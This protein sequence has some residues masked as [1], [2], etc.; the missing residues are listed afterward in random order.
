MCH[1]IQACQLGWFNTFSD[2]FRWKFW[3]QTTFLFLHSIMFG[4]FNF[5]RRLEESDSALGLDYPE[6]PFHSLYSVHN[7]VVLAFLASFY[8]IH[9]LSLRR[10]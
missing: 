3:V 5:S 7:L 6:T 1:E 4:E 2:T 9:S 8:A 10:V